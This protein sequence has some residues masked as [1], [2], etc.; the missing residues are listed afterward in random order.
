VNP[1]TTLNLLKFH[2]LTGF[3]FLLL[4]TKGTSIAPR[5]TLQRQSTPVVPLFLECSVKSL[6]QADHTP[7]TLEIITTISDKGV[8]SAEGTLT[9]L[10]T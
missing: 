5:G 1:L 8:C 4:Y 9:A 7:F 2:V 3:E 6:C 10:T